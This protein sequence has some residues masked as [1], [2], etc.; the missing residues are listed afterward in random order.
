M[1]LLFLLIGLMA[2]SAELLARGVEKLNMGLGQGMASGVVLGTLTSLPETIVVITALLEDKGDVALGSAIGGNIVLLT[3]GIGL[4]GLV[5]NFKWKDEL[6][7][8]GDYSHELGVISLSTLFLAVVY[9]YGRLTPLTSLPLFALYG[10]YLLHR[11]RGRNESGKR[12]SPVSV[13]EILGGGILMLILSPLF[14]GQL[15]KLS[16][17]LGTSDTYLAMILTPV[18]AELEEGVSALRLAM[19]SSE[20]GSSALLSY[21]GSKIQN[22]TFLLGLVGLISIPVRGP[23]LL[24]TLISN[25]LGTLVILDGKLGK[26]ESFLLSLSYFLLISFTVH[27]LP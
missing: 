4:V 15:E 21:F 3:L 8:G 7:M 19:R 24:L 23:Y 14:V 10:Y 26:L 2:L 13:L 9:V 1:W 20:G 18:V 22:I 11:V 17:S 5:Y 25:V 12:V 6:R 16:L 27:Y